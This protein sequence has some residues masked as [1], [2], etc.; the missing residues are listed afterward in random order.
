MTTM[1]SIFYKLA[2][3]K[4]LYINEIEWASYMKESIESKIS[5]CG[6]ISLI[7]NKFAWLSH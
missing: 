4:L 5:R 1:G 2:P 3:A 6:K 7:S